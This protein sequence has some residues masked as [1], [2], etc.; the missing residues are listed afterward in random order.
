M[1]K[2]EQ[3][4]LFTQFIDV[5][6]KEYEDHISSMLMDIALDY[7]AKN[8]IEHMQELEI[9]LFK[10]LKKKARM[11]SIE[12]VQRVAEEHHEYLP[13]VKLI[14]KE[15]VALDYFASAVVYDYYF[16]HI[17]MSRIFQA[18]KSGK[19]PSESAQ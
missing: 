6:Y 8:G 12:L 16:L 7:H 5:I 1:T 10:Q 19:I 18:I 13:I 9:K 3:A 17:A 14:L 2:L 15:R 4:R 11:M